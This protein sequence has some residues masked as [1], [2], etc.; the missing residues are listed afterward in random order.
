MTQ[1]ETFLFGS[2]ALMLGLSLI[3]ANLLFLRQKHRRV[4]LPLGFFFVSQVISE[5]LFLFDLLADP[6][7]MGAY[8]RL[9][10]GLTLPVAMTQ[11]PLFWLYVRALTSEDDEEPL[12]HKTLHALPLCFA[13]CAFVLYQTLPLALTNGLEAEIVVVTGWNA[14]ALVAVYT[15]V[16]L[17]YLQVA[18][19]VTLTI[20]LLIRHN[21]RLK[22]LF[23]S[24][25]D[26]ELTWVWWIAFAAAIYLVFSMVGLLLQMMGWWPA[27]DLVISKEVMDQMISAGLIWV[28]AL[29]G[30][31][32]KPGLIRQTGDDDG[33]REELLTQEETEKY[34]HSAL[35]LDHSRRIAAKIE[36]AMDKDLLYRD[37]NLSLWD[38]AKHIG[39]TSNYVSQTLNET[40]GESFFDYVNRWRIKDA[41]R[42]MKSTEET[43]L[44]L[45]YDVGFNSR[46]SFY[47]A[48]KRETGMTPSELRR[49]HDEDRAA[50]GSGVV[51][52]FAPVKRAVTK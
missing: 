34:K 13:V 11:A 17:F 38:L 33:G 32:Q 42:Q 49:K 8:L 36:A 25:E 30:L 21:S 48:F 29:W 23:A 4:F 12:R 20:R 50:G 52:E 31:R 6:E 47:K 22:D 10:V 45:A 28:I 27:A 39:V 35:T 16:V 26:R 2:T 40:L 7:T 41:V 9:A 24:T 3:C 1:A 43:I 14:F 51:R 5:L 15:G 44:V 37:P 18:F 19:Y 46:S